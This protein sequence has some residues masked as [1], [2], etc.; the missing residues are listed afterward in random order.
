MYNFILNAVLFIIAFLMLYTSEHMRHTINLGKILSWLY[1]RDF[2]DIFNFLGAILIVISLI[3]LPLNLISLRMT[4]EFEGTYEKKKIFLEYNP[5]NEYETIMFRNEKLEI[6]ETLF[7]YQ[8][9]F[10]SHPNWTFVTEKIMEFEPI[11]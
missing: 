6:N 4:R 9:R 11:K 7:N 1:V 5:E 3:Y 2:E 8:W 10:E